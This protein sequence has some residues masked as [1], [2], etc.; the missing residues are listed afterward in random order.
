MA[1]V[2]EGQRER[3]AHENDHMVYT[4]NNPW[5]SST[6]GGFVQVGG[7]PSKGHFNTSSGAVPSNVEVAKLQEWVERIDEK[8]QLL[9]YMC[10]KVDQQVEKMEERLTD[11]EYRLLDT[12][13][14]RDTQTKHFSNTLTSV[15]LSRNFADT[16]A[17]DKY[18]SDIV[19]LAK[20]LKSL[21]E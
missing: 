7:G 5:S 20:N 19:K 3:E 12:Q 8:V 10:P 17:V 9:G 6:D 14:M 13:K 21:K 1:A 4:N 11:I 18:Q 15:D 16:L 2:R